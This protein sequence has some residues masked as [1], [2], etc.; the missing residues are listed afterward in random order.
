VVGPG[1]ELLSDGTYNYQYDADGNCIE[2]TNIATGAV[3][4]YTWDNRNRLI[5][6]TDRA[7][8]AGPATEVVDLIYDVENRWIGETVNPENGQPVHTTLFAYDGNQIVLQ[9]QDV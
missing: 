1:N 5:A 7:S 9:F 4:D 2:R 3:T 8:A 6:V